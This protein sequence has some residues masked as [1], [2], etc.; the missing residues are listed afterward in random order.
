M[1]NKI[2]INIFEYTDYKLFLKDFYANQKK[3]NRYFSYRYFAQKTNVAAS[4]LK[5]IISGRRN[6][7][8]PVMNKYSAV[9]GLNNKEK[10]YFEVLTRFNNSRNNTDKNLFFI[11]MIRLRGKTGIKFL[12]EKHYEFFSKWYHSV[13]REF[14]TLQK[15]KEDPDWIGKHLNPS[16]SSTQAKKS[17]E[18]LLNIGILKRNKKGELILVDQ[19]ISSEYEMASA[20]L[21]NFHSQMIDLAKKANEEIPRECREISS[22]TLGLSEVCFNRIKERIRIFKEEILNMVVEDTGDSETVCQ[23]NFQLFPLIRQLRENDGPERYFF[24]NG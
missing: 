14:V 12:G 18:L 7:T 20:V 22:L 19:V 4:V 16:I 17:L 11:E 1:S 6:L 2:G 21:R 13:I 8:I 23:L 9:M 5:D 15:F 10:L 24:K 3:H